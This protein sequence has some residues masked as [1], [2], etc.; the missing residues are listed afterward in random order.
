[1][2]TV[3][4]TENESMVHRSDLVDLASFDDPIVVDALADHLKAHG[5]DS[6]VYDEGD[7]QRFIFM[8]QPKGSKK[9]QVRDD[10]YAKGVELLI[11]FEKNHPEHASLIH[12]C[13]ECG[14]FAVEYPQ[15][16]RKFFTPLL[17]EWLGNLGLFEK[18]FYCRKCHYTWPK[19]RASGI[20]RHHLNPNQQV[21][22]APPA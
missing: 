15:Y 4:E 5:V 11:D 21:F 1:M 14:S 16:T 18:E 9:I 20:N 13:P 7:F 8:T 10:D 22:V 19:K 2:Q 17:I 12:S 3:L 6:D